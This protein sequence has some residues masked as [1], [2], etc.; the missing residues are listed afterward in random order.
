MVQFDNRYIRCGLNGPIERDSSWFDVPGGKIKIPRRTFQSAVILLGFPGD[1]PEDWFAESDSWVF[2]IHSCA[3]FDWELPRRLGV[4]TDKAS[5]LVFPGAWPSID[6]IV[7]RRL[8]NSVIMVFNESQF[9]EQDLESSLMKTANIVANHQ[10][11]SASFTGICRE[12]DRALLTSIPCR[13]HGLD[14]LDYPNESFVIWA[15]FLRSWAQVGNVINS[16]GS[17]DLWLSNWIAGTRRSPHPY[18]LEALTHSPATTRCSG[19]SAFFKDGLFYLYAYILTDGVPARNWHSNAVQAQL[20]DGSAVLNTVNLGALRRPI[21]NSAPVNHLDAE[22]SFGAFALKNH[23][24]LPLDIFPVGTT[25]IRM[26][27]ATG[28]PLRPVELNHYRS[29]SGENSLAYELHVHDGRMFIEV[30]Q[31]KA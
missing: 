2:Q 25:E 5:A 6:E 20:L 26:T 19:F 12:Y 30:A 15:S 27:D 9:E 22:N 13:W 17:I 10:D 4:A 14:I 18:F 29:L 21:L 7:S 16:G 8:V 3:D 23:E 11:V 28:Y 1:A 31:S 24:G